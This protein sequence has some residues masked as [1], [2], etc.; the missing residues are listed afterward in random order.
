MIAAQNSVPD[1][2]NRNASQL[3]LRC[4]DHVPVDALSLA[5][6]LIWLNGSNPE[7]DL[8]FNTHRAMKWETLYQYIL[9]SDD[10]SNWTWGGGTSSGSDMNFYSL[11]EVPREKKECPSTVEQSGAHATIIEPFGN[12]SIAPCVPINHFLPCIKFQLTQFVK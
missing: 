9:A 10:H 1:Y 7:T 5:W 11:P 6:P 3:I 2:E 12:F 4:W 8:Q